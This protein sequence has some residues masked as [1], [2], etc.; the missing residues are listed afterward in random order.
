MHSIIYLIGYRGSGKTTVGRLLAARLG[1]DFVDADAMLEERTGK[2]IR[3]IFAT[4]GEIAFRTLESEILGELAK[5]TRVVIA[6]GGGVVLREKNRE[7]LKQSGFVA[8]LSADPATLWGRIQADSTT[9]ARR[10]D[11]STGGLAEVEQLL[12]TRLPIYRACADVETPVAAISPE[13]AA[14]AI[15]A[16]WESSK[17]S[18]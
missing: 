2:T 15:L 7:L 14:D 1:W 6:T 8:W 3:E 16:A 17:S 11:L 9:A 5:R 18:G 4:E 12:A 13:Q 10:P